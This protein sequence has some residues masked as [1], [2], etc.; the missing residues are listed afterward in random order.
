MLLFDCPRDLTRISAATMPEPPIVELTKAV[1][2]VAFDHGERH[3]WT[4]GA[5]GNVRRALRFLLAIQD[6]PGAMIKASTVELL[7]VTSLP[8]NPAIEVLNLAG[9]LDDDRVP[10]I[11]RWFEQRVE[12]LPEQMNAELH[13]WFEVMRKG[14]S[15]HPRWRPRQDRTTRNHFTNALPILRIW[16]RT[17]TSLRE[18]TRDDVLRALESTG[19]RRTDILG[20]LRAIFRVLKS[21][22][23]VFMDPTARIPFGTPSA[24]VPMPLKPADLR[25]ALMSDDSARAAMAS[26]LIF[27]GLRPRQLRSMQL[28]DLRD[29]RLYIDDQVILLAPQVGV[30]LAAYLKHRSSRWPNTANPHVFINHMIATGVAQ[31]T[32]AWV[33]KALGFHAQKLREDRILDEVRASAGDLRRVC[34]MFGLTVNGALRYIKTLGHP[35]LRE[36]PQEGG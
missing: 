24:Q 15:A 21:R 6:T 30:R 10:A 18:I 28:T 23:L 26:L 22:K 4:A 13:V 20:G 14:S 9:L 35:D 29:G 5:I 19:T 2:A 12:T 1:E 3:G 32:S 27:H 8:V 17:R 36:Q 34:D 16:G 33:N 25:S 31:T 11:V 7:R